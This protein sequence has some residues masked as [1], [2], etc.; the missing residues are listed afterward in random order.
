MRLTDNG[1]PARG[2]DDLPS[3]LALFGEEREPRTI[4]RQLQTAQSRPGA[5]S[6]TRGQS[7]QLDS[8]ASHPS[9]ML[10][11]PALPDSHQTTIARKLHL[12][13]AELERFE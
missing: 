2:I 13:C 5:Q 9:A 4:E 1:S 11:F 10:V 6:R 3:K 12:V 7:E 8:I